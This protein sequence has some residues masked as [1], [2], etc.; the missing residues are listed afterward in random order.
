MVYFTNYPYLLPTLRVRL[1]PGKENILWVLEYPTLY[2]LY[3]QSCYTQVSNYAAN[4]CQMM[5]GTAR[6]GHQCRKTTVISCRRRLIDTGV[7]KMND[8]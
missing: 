5:N 4:T 7:V 3:R 2:P 1:M 6:I 8:I